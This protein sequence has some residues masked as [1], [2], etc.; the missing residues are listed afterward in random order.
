MEY[1]IS[2]DR[3][4]LDLNVIHDFLSNRSY[5]A[6][7]RSLE[8]VQTSME[9]CICFGLCDGQGRTIGFAR[10]LTDGLVMACLLDVFILEPYQGRGLGTYLLNYVLN[11]AGIAVKTWILRTAD[12]HSFYEKFGFERLNSDDTYMIRGEHSLT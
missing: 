4:Q 1:S 8:E 7:G 10:V 9:N 2:S 6:Q 11:D 5:W 3:T 12:A